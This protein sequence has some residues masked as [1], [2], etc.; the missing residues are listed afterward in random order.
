MSFFFANS[1]GLLAL[2][3]VPAIVA[4]HFLQERSRRVRASTLFLLEHVQPTSEGGF[5]LE[6]FRHSLPFWM[7]ILAACALSWLLADPRWIRDESRQTVVVVLDSSASMQAF[8]AE[9]LAALADRLRPWEA[10]AAGTDWHLLE[11][12]PRR[13]PL[14]AGMQL[15]ELLAA[16]R[17]KW[18]PTQ[19]THAFT[20]ALAVGATLF[21]AGKG[22]VILVTDR[23]VDV[24]A[25]VAVLS[26]G[27]P[28]GNV[29]LS[30]G[31]V[32]MRNGAAFWR[33]LVTNHGDSPATRDVVV[34]AAGAD[35]GL[36]GERLGDPVAVALEPGQSR[37][38]EGEW[39]GGEHDRIVLSLTPD[40]F[41]VDDALPLVKPVARRV[42]LANGLA[43]PV[44]ERLGRMLTVADNVD[45][46]PSAAEADL[47]IDRI[48]TDL[49]ASAVL[50]G[51]LAEEK[52]AYDPAFVA[53][54]DHPLTRDLGW[55]ALLTGPAGGL[56]LSAADE[57]LL[58]KGTQPLAF[59]RTTVL[60][61]EPGQRGGRRIESLMLNFDVGNSN[62]AQ[63]PA[64]LVMLQRFLERVRGEIRRGWTANVETDQ[65]VDLPGGRQARTPETPGFFSVPLDA[66]A[67]TGGERPVV[68]GAAQFADSRESDLRAAAPVDTLATIRMERA[69]KQSIEDPWAPLWVAVA[70]AALLVA[71]GWR[72]RS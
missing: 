21:P 38:L 58:W 69:L 27:E 67:E 34:R 25:S 70:A 1:W 51:P 19:G 15:A 63:T 33:A 36:A 22:A 39:P 71:W 50:V 18:R 6:R 46:A 16:A 49:G 43:G 68:A 64:V 8:R 2:A 66:S 3:A 72:S 44:G 24:P 42:R 37:T 59:I 48:G 62:V 30:G 14:F 41:A 12:G 61:A 47:V 10:A 13:P 5:R 26:V 54:E 11:T 45:A 32:T 55:G 17:E 40:R 23:P 60:R 7:Q 57:P 35:G 53:A 4:I 20:D 31:D 65:A 28:V 29:G 56:R 52:G 9:T